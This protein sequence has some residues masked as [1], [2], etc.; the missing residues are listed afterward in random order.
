MKQEL[1]LK[2][3]LKL[4]PFLVQ[5]LQ[6]LQLPVLELKELV[7][8]EVN[9]NPFLELDET[10][11]DNE[12]FDSVSTNSEF[13]EGSTF[14]EDAIPNRS[15]SLRKKLLNQ[16]FLELKTPSEKAV[17]EFIVDNLDG[18]GFLSLSE[19]EIADHLKIDIKTIKRVRNLV[20]H[21]D[22][23]GC[24]SYSLSECFTA[25]MEELGIDEKFIEAVKGFEK[26]NN[27]DELGLSSED[28]ER[29]KAILRLLDTQPGNM[30]EDL[31]QVVPDI[32][33]SIEKGKPIIT[34]NSKEFKIR[35]N[36]S[37]LRYMNLDEA[38]EFI[39][40]KYRRALNL[41]QAIEK[42]ESTLKSIAQVVFRRQSR[43]F[44]EGI[45]GLGPLSYMDVSNELDIHVSTVS[46]AVK[47]KF[48]Q[49]PAG[50]FPFNSFFKKAVSGRTPLFI[51][52][53]IRDVI[54]SEDKFNPFND[55]EISLLLKAKNVKVARRTVAK[56]REE[57]G[58]PK[59]S[60]RRLRK[61]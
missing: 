50:I 60:V 42:R 52:N 38:K 19:E 56:Y 1:S 43:F 53:A 18:R 5:S 47:D 9:S 46:R 28:I 6:V 51:K 23:V 40:K 55:S 39:V 26:V 61:E 25:Q 24:A 16:A 4:T 15:F 20:R 41:K 36:S 31:V 2:L 59:A 45:N 10:E 34:L 32:F 3:H 33:V 22:P 30:G 29:L 37:Y 44:N 7:R 17:A 14:D 27:L 11:K 21:L 57:L 48:V 58:F 35:V 54:N 8:D 13:S 12:V 49:T